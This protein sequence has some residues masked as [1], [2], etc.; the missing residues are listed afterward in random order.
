MGDVT[1]P[2]DGMLEQATLHWI[3]I[4][5]KNVRVHGLSPCC[6]GLCTQ[7]DTQA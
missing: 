4:D 3:V 1:D 2:F 7:N 6:S 5:Q